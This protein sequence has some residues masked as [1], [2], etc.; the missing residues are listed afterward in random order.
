[1]SEPTSEITAPQAAAPAAPATPPAGMWI[2]A[3][4][5]LGVVLLQ[6]TVFSFWRLADGIPDVVV[7]AVVAVALLRGQLVGAVTGFAAGL[8]VELTS[9]IDT[10]GVLALLYLLVGAVAGRY[11]EREESRGLWSPLV[12]TVAAAL[13]VHVAFT[14]VQVSLGKD[15]DAPDYVAS[16]LLPSLLLTALLAPPILLLARKV[17]GQPRV[18]EPYRLGGTS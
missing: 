2:V 3:L 14:V 4:I 6:V 16:A 9:P 17:L 5:A 11:C 12:M 1:M 18:V 13:F 10:L 8:A 15:L 7:P